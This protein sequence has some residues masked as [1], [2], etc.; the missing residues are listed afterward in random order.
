MLAAFQLGAEPCEHRLGVKVVSPCPGGCAPAGELVHDI[1][2]D[3]SH[4]RPRQPVGGKRDLD[5]MRGPDV[6]DEAGDDPAAVDMGER[7]VRRVEA[8]ADPAADPGSDFLARF[9]DDQIGVPLS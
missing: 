1:V 8:D 5:V 9:G 4:Q 6:E 7:G 3:R 2:K